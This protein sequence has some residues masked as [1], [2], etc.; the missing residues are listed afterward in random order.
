MLYSALIFS[1]VLVSTHPSFLFHFFSILSIF[2]SPISSSFFFFLSFPSLF[3]IHFPTLLSP[4]LLPP[5]LLIFSF[6]SPPIPSLSSF[7]SPRSSFV[8]IILV[9]FSSLIS[10]NHL[11][12]FSLFSS[13]LLC[14]YLSLLYFSLILLLCLHSFFPFSLSLPVFLSLFLLHPLAIIVITLLSQLS[15]VHSTLAPM[16]FSSSLFGQLSSCSN[17]SDSSMFCLSRLYPPSSIHSSLYI[18]ISSSRILIH[19]S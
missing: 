6:L 3:P 16:S 15:F 7:S 1:S 11:S 10:V 13:S 19:S 12:I 5:S 14:L 17:S 8:I 18:L 2:T 4:L 9:L